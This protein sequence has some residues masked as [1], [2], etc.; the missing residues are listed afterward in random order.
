M[1]Y[2]KAYIHLF[3]DKYYLFYDILQN[4]NIKYYFDNVY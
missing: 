1:Q 2:V 3:L 4:V